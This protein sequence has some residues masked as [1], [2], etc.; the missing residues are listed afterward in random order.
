MI[1]KMELF[2]MD[3]VGPSGLWGGAFDSLMM[4]LDFPRTMSWGKICTAYS[5]C[6]VA[7]A[8]IR[9][10]FSYPYDAVLVVGFDI[11][12]LKVG[13]YFSGTMPWG[14]IHTAYSRCNGAG[15][16]YV[17]LSA[18][19]MMLSL[20]WALIYAGCKSACISAVGQRPAAK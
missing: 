1:C 5:R 20:W 16:K 4:P 11:R 3:Y 14:K 10:A 13:V 6:N 12:R 8:E 17:W 15:R 7:G 9:R 2:G 19:R 18:I